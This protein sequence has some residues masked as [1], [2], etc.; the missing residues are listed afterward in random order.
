MPCCIC[1]DSS[2]RAIIQM[3][4]KY[5]HTAGPGLNF[6]MWP[7]QTAANVSVKVPYQP[8]PSLVGGVCRHFFTWTLFVQGYAYP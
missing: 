5:S 4:G 7:F 1:V 8:S 6:I 2:E 3:F